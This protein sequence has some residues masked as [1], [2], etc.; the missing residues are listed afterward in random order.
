MLIVPAAA[1]EASTPAATQEPAAQAKP[2]QTQE[3]K[4]EPEYVF[5]VN[6]V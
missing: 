3:D 2:A 4:A 1:Q 6:V 5:K